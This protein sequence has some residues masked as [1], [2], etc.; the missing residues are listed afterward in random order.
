MAQTNGRPR[1]SPE[2]Y[3]RELVE[4]I[5][6]AVVDD[7]SAVCVTEVE[8][9]RVSLIVVEV[10][11]SDRGKL[12]GKAGATAKAIRTLL[13]AAGGKVQRRYVLEIIDD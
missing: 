6:K 5:A 10:A 9:N 8:G 7:P 11:R 3:V 4:A 2:V 12:I 13:A 1:H